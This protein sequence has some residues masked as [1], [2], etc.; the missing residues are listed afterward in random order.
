[1][2]VLDWML[3]LL[4]LIHSQLGT[5]GN[6]SATVILHAFQFTTAH[7]LGFS[8]LTSRILATDLSQYHW[9]FKSHVKSSLHCLIPFLPLFCSCQFRR[10]DSIQFRAHIQ[11]G[12]PKLDSSLPNTVLYSV[13]SRQL[14]YTPSR[15]LTM[16]S[17]N[18]SAR[19]PR[20]TPSSIVQNACFLVLYLAMDVLLSCA[21]VLRECVYRPVA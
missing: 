11:A 5:T 16:L 19:T 20:K 13:Y 7:A 18:S 4:H 9:N 8:V 3:D 10:L 2:R 12:F 17:Y 6:Y 1:M 15:L 14:S 21:C